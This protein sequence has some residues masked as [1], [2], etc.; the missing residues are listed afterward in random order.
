MD[1]LTALRDIEWRG[2]LLLFLFTA[3]GIFRLD[4]IFIGEFGHTIV[5]E[6]FP[7]FLETGRDFS[8]TFEW[9]YS[10]PF[11]GCEGALWCT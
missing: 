10:R 2:L 3:N 4:P 1:P 9:F 7:I 6:G 8:N 11:P 5:E